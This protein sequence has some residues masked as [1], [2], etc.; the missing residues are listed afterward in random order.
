MSYKFSQQYIFHVD[1]CRRKQP[2]R[3]E[4]AWKQRRVETSLVIVML[5]LRVMTYVVS[6]KVFWNWIGVV[7]FSCHE[8]WSDKGFVIWHFLHCCF[9]QVVSLWSL[10]IWI[11]IIF[12]TN[13]SV[14]K[15]RHWN[16]TPHRQDFL[17]KKNAPQAKLMKKN[18]PQAG[19]F[20]TESW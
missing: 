19:F 20:L 2:R 8:V 3:E 17:V 6:Y 14:D 4:T 11:R 1:F 10:S 7:Q 13:K 5:M 18:A 12:N 16:Q 9:L 15:I